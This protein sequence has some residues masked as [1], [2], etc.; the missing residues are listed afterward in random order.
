ML[1]SDRPEFAECISAL[2]VAFGKVADKSLLNCYWLFLADVPLADIVSGALRAG[3]TLKF[4]PTPAELREMAGVA[5]ARSRGL[6]AWVVVSRAAADIGSYRSV[7]FEDPII[8]AV[9]RS[10]GGWPRVLSLGGEEFDKWARMEFLKAYESLDQVACPE[11]CRPLSGL[12]TRE[13]V[14]PLRVECKYV[15]Q[16]PRLLNLLEQ[17]EL[18]HIQ[19]LCPRASEDRWL[20]AQRLC[21]RMVP[22]DDGSAGDPG[23]PPD[24]RS[25]RP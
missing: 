21:V 18:A 5:T 10:L 12:G 16:N 15:K 17:S 11:D 23:S 4:M 8:N 2:A 13:D 25:S 3:R 9:I 1:D 19:A 7:F 6:L 14:G 22:S 20:V 24:V